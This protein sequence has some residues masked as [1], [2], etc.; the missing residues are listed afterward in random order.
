MTRITFYT[1]RHKLKTCKCFTCFEWFRVW[2]NPA[3]FWTAAPF[4]SSPVSVPPTFKADYERLLT[5]EGDFCDHSC[6]CWKAESARMACVCVLFFD[7]YMNNRKIRKLEKSLKDVKWRGNVSSKRS[8]TVKWPRF[9]CCKLS[10]KAVSNSPKRP[11]FL[12]YAWK[13]VK[14]H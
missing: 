7:K 3:Y 11:I 6:K 12:S 2:N 9:K 5:A 13:L 8:Y 1:W 10:I 4:N 14:H